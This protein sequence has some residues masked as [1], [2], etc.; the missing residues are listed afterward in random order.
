MEQKIEPFNSDDISRVE[1]QRKWVREHYE[2][3]AEHKYETIDGKLNLLDTIIR[4]KWIE[5]SETLKLQCLGITLGDALVQRLD[6]KWMS[7]EDEYGR[8]P[9]LIMEGTSIVLFP[10][11]MISKRIEAGEE[12]DIYE[13]FNGI[14]AKVEEI[15][16][17]ELTNQ[18]T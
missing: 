7:V 6:L 1:A 11:T 14:C 17:I 5:P 16:K 18:S 9:A 10:L 4:N 8:D 13:I 3:E 2:P 12:V 15:K